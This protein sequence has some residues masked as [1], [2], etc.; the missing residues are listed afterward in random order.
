MKLRK[1]IML[2][3]VCAFAVAL[4]GCGKGAAGDHGKKSGT[5]VEE[6][7]KKGMDEYDGKGGESNPGGQTTQPTANPTAAPAG[8]GEGG[9]RP[10]PNLA[11]GVDI[12]LSAVSDTVAY[13]EVYSMM[14]EPEGYMDKVVK[15]SGQYAH[16]YEE[17]T[18]NNYFACILWD[19]TGCCTEGLEFVLGPEYKYPDDYPSEGDKITVVGVFDTYTE[20][21]YLYCTLRNAKFVK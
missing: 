10:G 3:A 13:T 1:V 4:A 6:A 19:S 9:V 11:E 2:I 20:G 7:L 18:G 5:G 17:T 12:D 14:L 15:I 8:E 21:D 16:I